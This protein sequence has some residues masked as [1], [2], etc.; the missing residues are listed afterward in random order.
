MCKL[1][2]TMDALIWF[3]LSVYFLVSYPIAILTKKI[4][5]AL[6][7][8]FLII[9]YSL[10]FPQTLFLNKTIIKRATFLWFISSVYS[11]VIY[12]IIFSFFCHNSCND[13]VYL[14]CVFS[15]VLPDF[16]SGYN[17][18][19]KGCSDIFFHKH[20][21]STVLISMFTLRLL[22]LMKTFLHV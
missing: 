2:S 20:S 13:M 10:V 6:I 22:S 21:S 18:C 4:I 1:F 14:Q 15:S 8:Q 5:M 9:V 12:K 11:H 7:V 3:L 17:F 16:Y 19:H